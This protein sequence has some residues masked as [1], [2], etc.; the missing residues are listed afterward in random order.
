MIEEPMNSYW[1][2]IKHPRGDVR[3]WLEYFYPQE[4]V[5]KIFNNYYSFKI[6]NKKSDK[7]DFTKII[8]HTKARIDVC[9]ILI[10]KFKKRY[11]LLL[12]RY[13]GSLMSEIIYTSIEPLFLKDVTSQLKTMKS[14]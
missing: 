14:I 6:L 7:N 11:G 8:I 12:E 3:N 13:K 5:N 9:R 10:R 1:K 2:Y 4:R